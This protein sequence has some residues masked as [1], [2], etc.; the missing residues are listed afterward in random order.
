MVFRSPANALPGERRKRLG[1]AFLSQQSPSSSFLTSVVNA[2]FHSPFGSYVI[3]RCQC[4]E[5]Q[6]NALM[7]GR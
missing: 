7:R 2:G 1:S 5:L 6:S 3:S 4:E